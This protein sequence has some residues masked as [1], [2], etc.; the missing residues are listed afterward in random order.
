M[1]LATEAPDIRI[2][3]IITNDPD[4]IHGVKEASQA[5]IVCAPPSLVAAIH[6]ATG[7]LDHF[8]AGDAGKAAGGAE[9]KTGQGSCANAVVRSRT[10][11]GRRMNHLQEEVVEFRQHVARWVDE[12]LLP[13]AERLDHANE[14]DVPLFREIGE[15]GYIGTLYP[16]VRRR[17]RCGLSLHL[18]H[19]PVRGTGARL[20]GLCRRGLHAGFDGDQHDPRMGQRGTQGAPT[21]RRPCAARRSAPSP[22]PSRTRA[23]M[24]RR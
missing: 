7:D 17:Q 3:H 5:A 23:R 15:L 16:G 14:F 11:K 19:D 22:S 18:L 2:D 6:D 13:Q 1:P 9:G 8:A 4:G 24:R 20:D 12:R 21:S 10:G